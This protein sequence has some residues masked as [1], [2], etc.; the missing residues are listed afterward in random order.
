MHM[1]MCCFQARSYKLVNDAGIIRPEI[2]YKALTIWIDRDVLGY[3]FSQV[4]NKETYS[5]E[6]S[7]CHD[8]RRKPYRMNAKK[9]PITLFSTMLLQ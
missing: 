1:Y 8:S 3:A 6:K 9:L 5:V 2:F 4:C 7:A